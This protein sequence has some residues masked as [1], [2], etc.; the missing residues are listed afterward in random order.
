VGSRVRDSD[1][2]RLRVWKVATGQH[3]ATSTL[4]LDAS[5]SGVQAIVFHP[6]GDLV[7][8]LCGDRFGYVLRLSSGSHVGRLKG[9]NAGGRHSR[10]TAAPSPPTDRIWRSRM[11]PVSSV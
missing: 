9:H 4:N 7:L 11:T 6:A 1:E 3:L 5:A 8:A 10:L 2:H